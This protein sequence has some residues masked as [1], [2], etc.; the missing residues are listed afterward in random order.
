MYVWH[1]KKTA[2]TKSN[3]ISQTTNTRPAEQNYGVRRN[4]KKKQNEAKKVN[5]GLRRNNFTNI[6][7][8][9]STAE[10]KR[11][12]GDRREG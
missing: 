7:P 3:T 5:S 6:Q 12:V 4:T 8:F 11:S 9:T 10:H 1:D 2:K